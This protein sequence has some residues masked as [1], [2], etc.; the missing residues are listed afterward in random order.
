MLFNRIM[1]I[2]LILVAIIFNIFFDGYLALFVL[3]FVILL[4]VLSFVSLFFLR[5]QLNISVSA[6]EPV[7]TRKSK[8]TVRII[9]STNYRFLSGKTRLR[10]NSKNTFTNDESRDFIYISPSF[11]IHT[12][13]LLFNSSHSGSLIFTVDEVKV[14]DFL[15]LF[16]LKKNFSEN[17]SCRI[18]VLPKGKIATASSSI[19]SGTEGDSNEYSKKLAGDDPSE[20]FDIRNYR[21]GDRIRRIHRWLS[22]KHDTI[23]V[24]DFGEPVS[25]G[26]LILVDFSE[27]LD[28]SEAALDLLYGIINN[29]MENDIK[30]SVKWYNGEDEKIND[31][32]TNTEFD[33][34]IF[35]SILLANAKCK[36]G[37]LENYIAA[38]D[39]GKY[40]T[41]I[42]ICSCPKSESIPILYELAQSIPTVIYEIAESGSIML[43]EIRTVPAEY[44]RFVVQDLTKERSFTPQNKGE[45]Y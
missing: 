25:E 11:E 35:F 10:I 26:V 16:S 13:D 8:S 41:F 12:V 45:N 27:N 1:Y 33:A 40:S 42:Y 32:Y 31:F 23:I 15:M 9:L 18:T 7:N 34:Q 17:N 22:E 36:S 5:R 37:L 6:A 39:V 21:E 20:I 2:L 14:Y 28:L 4:P 30:P 44:H 43:D 19:K 3:A 29:L 38:D 24:K